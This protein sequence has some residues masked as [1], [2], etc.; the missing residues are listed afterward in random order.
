MLTH[1]RYYTPARLS[2]KPIKL[3]FE[4]AN[5]RILSAFTVFIAVFLTYLTPT[6]AL[7]TDP[8][9]GEIICIPTNNPNIC[10]ARVT[11]YYE[12]GAWPY[13][14]NAD[15]PYN[16]H[17]YPDNYYDVWI[18]VFD[19]VCIHLGIAVGGQNSMYNPFWLISGSHADS[20]YQRSYLRRF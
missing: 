13:Y 18:D 14:S 16:N 17:K 5:S 19:P 12:N 11:I 20:V 15:Y 8:K 3:R 4:M 10:Q 6:L 7:A 1:R 9:T 2:S